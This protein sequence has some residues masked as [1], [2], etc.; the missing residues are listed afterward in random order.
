MAFLE[1][2][3]EGDSLDTKNPPPADT[4]LISRQLHS[5]DIKGNL[6]QFSGFLHGGDFAHGNH[7]AQQIA[8]GGAF[9]G[10]GG[11]RNA[12]GLGS[13]LIE[14]LILAAAA[15]MQRRL[16]GLPTILPR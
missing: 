10:A 12:A 16:K 5:F 8:D 13:E 15:T 1:C 11:D 3:R 6:D 14:E 7:L 9:G 4:Y 2:V